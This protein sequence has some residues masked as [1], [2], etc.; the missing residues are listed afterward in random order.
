MTV[1]FAQNCFKT[2][3]KMPETVYLSGEF[4]TALMRPDESETA[5]NEVVHCDFSLIDISVILL[6]YEIFNLLFESFF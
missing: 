3:V 4:L 2:T 5:E 1:D 6:A